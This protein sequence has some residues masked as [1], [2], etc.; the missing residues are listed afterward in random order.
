MTVSSYSLIRPQCRAMGLPAWCEPDP[1]MTTKGTNAD[2]K[3]Q[4]QAPERAL[5]AECEAFIVKM[6]VM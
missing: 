6:N 4:L 2:A 1:G 5:T 3:G